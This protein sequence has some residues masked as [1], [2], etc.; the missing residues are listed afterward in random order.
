MICKKCKSSNV[1]V[2]TQSMVVSKSR[3]FIWNLLMLCITGGLWIFWM[4]I[5][6]R[7]EKHI[8]ETWA[9]C[10]NCGERWKIK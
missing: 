5:R 8:I 10:Q 1:V 4:L 2:N 3:S 6:K 7:K 9:T